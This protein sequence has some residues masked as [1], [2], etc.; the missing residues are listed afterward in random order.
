MPLTVL[1]HGHHRDPCSSGAVLPDTVPC[2]GL[3][4]PTLRW[5]RSGPIKTMFPWTSGTRALHVACGADHTLCL[6]TAPRSKV[7]PL[8][9]REF[10]RCWWPSSSRK[11]WGVDSGEASSEDELFVLG[12]YPGDRGCLP[13]WEVCCAP[14]SESPPHIPSSRSQG[15]TYL[16]LGRQQP[17]PVWHGLLCGLASEADAGAA[18]QG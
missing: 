6:A 5:S 9:V 18:A 1:M 4:P 10:G 14:V 7:F 16:R 3:L 13:G 2:F 15:W 8:P 12:R 17:R 11:C